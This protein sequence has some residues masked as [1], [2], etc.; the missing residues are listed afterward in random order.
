MNKII[1]ELKT[2]E[3]VIIREVEHSDSFA[4]LTIAQQILNEGLGLTSK[5]EF[6]NSIEMEQEWIKS[7]INNK[8]KK[9]FLVSEYQDK[10]VGFLSFESIEK[11]K[12]S[13]QGSFGISIDNGWRNKGL[14]RHLIEALLDWCKKNPKIEILR[15]EVLGS[16]TSAINLYKNLGFVEEGRLIKYIK[17]NSYYDELVLMA[18]HL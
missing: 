11:E 17:N 3:L 9:L 2:G 12:S 14:G 5:K 8:D 15:L 7:F 4:T 16:N 6:H 18:I 1:V 13:H 10:V